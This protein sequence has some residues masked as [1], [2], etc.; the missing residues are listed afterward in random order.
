[1]AMN[2]SIIPSNIWQPFE[3][4]MCPGSTRSQGAL[5][6][7]A[8]SVGMEQEVLGDLIRRVEK[9]P[10]VQSVASIWDATEYVEDKEGRI[11]K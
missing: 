7:P 3:K 2:S 1:M 9:D 4:D 8:K 6:A 10:P 11:S 5:E